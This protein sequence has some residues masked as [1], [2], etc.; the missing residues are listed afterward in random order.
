MQSMHAIESQ[1]EK[2]GSTLAAHRPVSGMA[3]WISPSPRL[4]LPGRLSLLAGKRGDYFRRSLL[5]RYM[6]AASQSPLR[7]PLRKWLRLSLPLSLRGPVSHE[8]R[9]TR[10]QRRLRAWRFAD[11]STPPPGRSIKSVIAVVIALS[12]FSAPLAL[13][14]CAIATA[15][16]PQ[17]FSTA[18]ATVIAS[19]LAMTQTVTGS[20]LPW[21]RSAVRSRAWGSS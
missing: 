21:Q 13:G 16:A 11:I 6:R 19:A 8:G 9:K 4:P 18:S 10:P 3:F 2:E 1:V 17:R 14:A 5:C 20:A 12:I 7:L 15:L